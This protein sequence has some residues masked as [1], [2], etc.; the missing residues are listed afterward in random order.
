MK[1]IEDLL[2]DIVD[3]YLDKVN[4]P[5]Q[6]QLILSSFK[7]IYTRGETLT[8]SQG[9]L[10]LKILNKNK[11][12]FTIAG[13][14]YSDIVENPEWKSRFRSLDITKK[15]S[16][17]KDD[18]GK[19]CLFVKFPYQVKDVFEKYSRQINSPLGIWYHEKKARKL[20][21]YDC[22]IIAL[23]EFFIENKFEL[24]ETYIEFMSSYEEMLNQQESTIPGCDIL[25]N[26]VCLINA[27]D[28]VNSWFESNKTRNIEDDLMLA[29]SMGYQLVKEP[30][31]IVEK[32][33]A[34]D[35]TAFWIK[36]PRTFLELTRKISGKFV[37]ILDRAHTGNSWL[38]EFTAVA[39][40]VGF[41]PEEIKVCFRADKDQGTDFN[42]WVKEKGYGGK[43]DTG[44]ILIFNHKPAKWI[45]KNPN[46][47]KI[48]CTNNLYPPTDGITRDWFDSH[49]CVIY[50]GEIKPS[51][52]KDKKIVSL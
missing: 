24:D 18:Q 22:N 28:D 48:I 42:D 39:E 36:S 31:T 27:S 50:L 11:I 37:V 29:K 51:K 2:I 52:N 4:V 49:P 12:F 34:T 7:N 10:L 16:V 6:E 45:F 26:Q 17:E 19:Y 15:V 35:E 40:D 9:Q 8:K 1:Y 43:V 14:D 30:N 5:T 47:I 41:T 21:L 38:K 3:N 25:D 33:A 20:P 44:K 46:E 23:N 32:I 13:L